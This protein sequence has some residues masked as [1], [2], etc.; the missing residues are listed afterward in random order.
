MKA[1][2]FSAQWEILVTAFFAFIYTVAS[3]VGPAL[4][5]TFVQYLNGRR[6]YNNE[7]YMLV[8]T[9]FLAKLVECLSQRHWFFRLQKVGIRMRSSLV[10][11]IY[12][13]GLTFM[14][15]KARTHK[16]NLGLAS[17]AA[18]IATILVMLVNSHLGGCK[19]GF[20]RS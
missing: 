7:G 15:L 11:M 1:L 6:Q 2:F 16:R 19:R 14:S 3:Y 13:K 18:L 20:R 10:A 9:F 8:I 4:I 5:D 12:E 17:I